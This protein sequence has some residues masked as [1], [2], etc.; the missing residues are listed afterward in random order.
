MGLLIPVKQFLPDA[1]NIIPPENKD[2]PQWVDI[3]NLWDN[4]E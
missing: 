3:M 1:S 2:M 4:E